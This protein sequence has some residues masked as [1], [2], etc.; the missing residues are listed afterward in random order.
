M[1]DGRPEGRRRW[2]PGRVGLAIG[3][4]LLL[5]TGAGAYG[6][7]LRMARERA[8]RDA[9]PMV[10]G[11]LR[12]EGL[13]GRLAIDRDARGIPHILALSESDAWFGLGF[14]HAQDRLGQMLWLRRVAQ[15]R[16]AEAIGEAGLA[17]DRL[18]RTLGFPKL[19]AAALDALRPETESALVAYAAG[20]NGRMSRVRS[21]RVAAPL[22][23]SPDDPWAA[24]P[25]RSRTPV[26]EVLSEE[27]P[28]R[29]IDTLA[30]G[31]LIAW[32][33]GASH[34]RA[35]VLSDLIERLG[36]MGARPFFPGGEQELGLAIPLDD[37]A[38]PEREREVREPT[39][40]FL[41]LASMRGSAWA[42]PGRST[43]SG[44]PIL[45]AELS[46][47]PSA[48]SLLYEAHL[49]GGDLDAAGVTVP[50]SPV[51]WAGRNP[52]MSWAAVPLPVATV[53]LFKE[54]LRRAGTPTGDG[55][56]GPVSAAAEESRPGM[57]YQ[58]GS[59]WVPVDERYEEIAVGREGSPDHRVERLRVRETRHGPLI[60]PVLDDGIRR[61]P[62]SLAWTGARPGDPIAGMLGVIRATD[63]DSLRDAL[64]RHQSPPVEVVYAA[65][66][67][68]VGLQVAGW[69]P[70][71]TLP[72]GLS[73]VPGRLRA[74][75]WR[76]RVEAEALPHVELGGGENSDWLVVSGT[77]LEEELSGIQME[78]VW[79]SEAR[80]RRIRS[81][82]GQLVEAGPV[83]LRGASAL[84]GDVAANADPQLV[85]A[86][87][88]LA[89]SPPE[90]SP[91]G[92][93]VALLLRS[94]DGIASEDSRGTVAFQLLIGHLLEEMLVPTIGPELM[95]RY[96]A[97]P[98]VEPT[99]LIQSIVLAA[100]QSGR[101]GGWTDPD[102]VSRAVREGLRRTWM[103]LSYRLGHNRERWTWGRLHGVEF[104]AFGASEAGAPQASPAL[105][106]FPLPGQGQ[107]I[108][109]AVPDRRSFETLRAASYRMAVDLASP[110]RM[111]T[112]LAPGQSEHPGHAHFDDGVL[113]W[114]EGRPALV[115][116]SRFLL[117]EASVERLVLEPAQ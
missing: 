15:G 41:S 36:S 102:A 77:R 7:S 113:P 28:W 18:V 117:E 116:T 56:P 10:A 101:R 81:L 20:V 63:V 52:E 32:G 55:T 2:L 8:A 1:T 111:L 38:G 57:L 103:S 67:G 70:Q 17:S 5:A 75:D 46:V 62:L 42:L 83:D 105:G 114:R 106:P 59:R 16:S 86:L 87:L 98:G 40:T 45:A 97:L 44:A 112:T 78:W 58:N 64:T 34:D 24:I 68:G 48:P 76:A 6:L 85:A 25:G 79:R 84:Q 89:G 51:L 93:E 94:W 92:E 21:G 88:R 108:A 110:D 73:P 14:A 13:T 9:F 30:V 50:G 4:I 54:S 74:F 99:T 96:L 95:D 115:V 65:R 33:A 26:T 80:A 31:M 19:A 91:E 39:R 104:A 69:L 61:A 27:E 35:V 82:L 100:A 66:S 60:N 22:V 47:R 53:D 71:R 43:V 23:L 12:V 37:P 11:Q 3:L 29:P 109:R 90:L 49:R 72:S 107:S